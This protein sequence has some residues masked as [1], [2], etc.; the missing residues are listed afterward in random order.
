MRPVFNRRFERNDPRRYTE[1]NAAFDYKGKPYK[2]NMQSKVQINGDNDW[3]WDGMGYTIGY[4]VAADQKI[5]FRGRRT[6]MVI[7]LSNLQ[8]QEIL[9]KVLRLN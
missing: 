8:M 7:L 2:S 1:T 4:D 6:A 3:G 5:R 9:F